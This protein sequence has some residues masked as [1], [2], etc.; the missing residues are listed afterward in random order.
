MK[1]DYLV[2]ASVVPTPQLNPPGGVDSHLYLEYVSDKISHA[3]SVLLVGGGPVAVELAG[4][5]KSKYPN[6]DVSLVSRSQTLCD[7]M[8]FNQ[9]HS[10]KIKHELEK[11][12]CWSAV[13]PLPLNW[14]MKSSPSTLIIMSLLCVV[15]R[16][17]VT[18]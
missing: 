11:L 15:R 2:I 17:S 10:D 4:E 5:I 16:P 6:R 9:E 14:R 13:V 12:A 8:N 18:R 7:K 1:Y 3:K